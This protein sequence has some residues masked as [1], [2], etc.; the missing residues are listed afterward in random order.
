MSRIGKMPIPV[1]AGVKVEID[2]NRVRVVG[3]LG[4]LTREFHP[5][6]RIVL[7]EGKLHVYRPNDERQM[8]VWL[9]HCPG[10]CSVRR[11]SASSRWNAS[12]SSSS[13]LMP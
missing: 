5:E 7:E 6:L 4:E 13:G 3:P 2:G 9:L 12:S 8:R 11:S 10:H 1:P